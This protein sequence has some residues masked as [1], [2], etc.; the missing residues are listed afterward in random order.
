M[1]VAVFTAPHDP[2]GAASPL[3]ALDE[4]G[5]TDALQ[6]LGCRLRQVQ[7][8]PSDG[9][10][11]YAAAAETGRRVGAEWGEDRP[12]L[13]L[14]DGYLS[15][16][17]GHAAATGQSPVI[18]WLGTIG[19]PD[20][21]PWRRLSTAVARSAAALFTAAHEVALWVRH[22]RLS[23]RVEVVQPAVHPATITENRPWPPGA[24][25]ARGRGRGRV[26][27]SLQDTTVAVVGH[28]EPAGQTPPR[29]RS[30]GTG[31]NP[32]VRLLRRASETAQTRIDVTEV[33]DADPARVLD[34][35]N[36]V[37]VVV[38]GLS[39]DGGRTTLRAMARGLAVISL[40]RVP[41]RDLVVDRVSGITARDGQGLVAAV[42]ELGSDPFLREALG[43]GAIDR[44]QVAHSAQIVAELLLRRMREVLTEP[45]DGRGQGVRMARQLG[46]DVSEL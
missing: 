28:Q 38:T 46:I 20:A 17:A 45:A 23:N 14:C 35:L 2:V 29:P 34:E 42:R 1:D 33:D 36:G 15:G 24:A 26:Q 43:Q 27:P 41:D 16:L 12:E 11:A 44:V 39:T 8:P 3:A 21:E 7:L 25:R 5:L 31:R 4:E 9:Q 18:L 30:D 40:P 37:D 22:E 10:D 19:L 6:Q 32:I 13:V